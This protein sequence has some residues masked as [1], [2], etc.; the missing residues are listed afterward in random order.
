MVAF[1]AD[2]A[3]R[4][5]FKHVT[6]A[7]G[8]QV[9]NY[10]DY[11]ITVDQIT[12]SSNS[13]KLHGSVSVTLGADI[14]VNPQTT[15]N[16]DEK[17]VTMN[18][19]GQNGATLTVPAGGMAIVQVPVLPVGDGNKFTVSIQISKTPDVTA[20][21][22]RTQTNGGALGRANLG[23]AMYTI[24]GPFSVSSTK[25]VVFSKGNLQYKPST[26][27]W[28][29]A[30]N[31]YDY[32]GAD[33]AYIANDYDGWIDLF[34]WGTGNNPTNISTTASDY[35]TFNDW[36]TFAD[37]NIG[38]GWYTLDTNEWKY[39]IKTDV[40]T[41]IP[42]VDYRVCR[43]Y[44][45][46][47]A[48]ESTSAR[49]TKAK[50]NGVQGVILFPDVYVHPSNVTIECSITHYNE[51]EAQYR[52]FLVTSGWDK[53]EL[54]GAIFLPVSGRRIGTEVKKPEVGFYW[55]TDGNGNY[56]YPFCFRAN[57]MDC[58]ATYFAG[59][60]TLKNCGFAVRLV[61]NVQ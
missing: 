30:A 20:T 13:Y 21:L 5:Y 57:E 24:G 19:G 54:A 60:R 61:H 18:F 42:G 59:E 41:A 12:I 3:T 35:N 38:S 23:Y 36:G 8:V 22:T 55:S 26:H 1:A 2:G 39:L 43:S 11:D 7:V 46:P 17:L 10:H 52:E 37:G 50:V 47:E 28:R 51:K 15:D 16:P 48:L 9:K 31:Q 4:L 33:N 27:T 25:K 29:F 34:G 58:P 6:A 14:V 45:L 40:T 49:F 53:M 44:G 56:G 32:I